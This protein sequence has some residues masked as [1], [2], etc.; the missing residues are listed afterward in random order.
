MNYQFEQ[1]TQK[2]NIFK[3]QL[4]ELSI[5]YNN[6]VR[7]IF[8]SDFQINE[9]ED[10]EHEI[11]RAENILDRLQEMFIRNQKVVS[12]C[13]ELILS[14]D[15]MKQILQ[16][17]IEERE[18]E[19]N[20]IGM[21]NNELIDVLKI[22]CDKKMNIVLEP[23][24]KEIARIKEKFQARKDSW[25]DFQIDTSQYTQKKEN[26]EI[27]DLTHHSMSINEI[28]QIEDW[29]HLKISEVVFDSENDNWSKENGVFNEKVIGK[30]KL[31]FLIQDDH[32]S[33]FGGYVNEKIIQESKW[34]SDP[35]A[36]LFSLKT[37]DNDQMTKFDVK[38]PT[39][40]FYLW[41]ENNTQMFGFGS[42][43][44]IG[45]YRETNKESSW[46][47]QSSERTFDYHHMQ[48]VFIHNQND[49]GVFT[50]E[51]ICVFSMH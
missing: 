48:N 45:I 39:K 31:V 14:L 8:S 20:E 3:T 2:V 19:G 12:N 24:L 10:I 40:V 6:Y 23:L 22:L 47:N 49:F 5:E 41:K 29:T 33:K 36:F 42:S 11:T 38:D 51:R 34:I 9:T 46:C 28:K 43:I 17:F 25:D 37:D 35:N 50:P 4:S 16:Q 32:G 21:K 27:I 1:I 30:D 7:R 18:Q 15:E 44:D 13:S 26:D